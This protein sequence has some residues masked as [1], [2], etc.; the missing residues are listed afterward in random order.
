MLSGK[1]RIDNNSLECL[2]F[3]YLA[4]T[5]WLISSYSCGLYIHDK[6]ILKILSSVKSLKF[7]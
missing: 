6:A 1:V 7:L 3:F 4:I 5:S 2:S